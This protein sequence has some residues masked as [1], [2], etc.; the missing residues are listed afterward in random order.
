MKV[1]AIGTLQP[2][3]DEQ[4]A[5]IFPDEVPATLKLY[6]G[7]KLEQFWL[8]YGMKGAVFLLNVADQE[9]AETL[10]GALPLTQEGLHRFEY[11]PIGPLSPLGLLIQ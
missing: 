3:S 7:G 1:L 9:E 5:R 2:L 11:F 4:S 10:I 8:R 6:L